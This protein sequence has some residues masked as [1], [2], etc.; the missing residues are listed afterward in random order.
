MTIQPLA[1]RPREIS[2]TEPLGAAY[3]RMK[4][5]L[6]SPFDAGKWLIIGFCAWLAQ[7]GES[8]GGSGYGYNNRNFGGKHQQSWD[9]IRH[10]YSVAHDYVVLNLVWLVPVAAFAFLLLLLLGLLFIWLSSHGK[11]MFLHC[12]A[13]NRAEI[14]IPWHQYGPVANRLFLFRLVL[15][16]AGLILILPLVVVLVL[17][18]VRMIQAGDFHALQIFLLAGIACGV[19]LVALALG[20]VQKVVNDFVVPILYLRG[21][22]CRAAGREF[23]QLLGAHA[24]AFVLYL[25]FQI[26]LAIVLGLMVLWLVLLTCCTAGCLLAIPYIGTVCLLPILVFQRAYSLCFLA[27]FGPAYDVFPPAAPPPLTPPPGLRPV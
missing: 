2:V 7:L 24:G 16:L 6:F 9:D 23:F 22:T 19:A 17:L 20:L 5:M 18:I 8:G 21:G 14:E 25:L 4:L 13:E 15:C 12:V 1:S 3:H 27:Q 11:F 10:A 26:L